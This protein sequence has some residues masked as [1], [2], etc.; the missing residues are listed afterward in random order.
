M[1]YNM[2]TVLSVVVTELLTIGLCKLVFVKSSEGINGVIVAL[3]EE[4]TKPKPAKGSCGERD[5]GSGMSR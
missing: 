1:G 3:T 2:S 4:G 5:V